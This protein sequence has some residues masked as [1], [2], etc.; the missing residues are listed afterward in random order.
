V[1]RPRFAVVIVIFVSLSLV[2]QLA[3][4]YVLRGQGQIAQAYHHAPVDWALF[5]CLVILGVFL[6]ILAFVF[7]PRKRLSPQT[8]IPNGVTDEQWKE[9]QEIQRLTDSL[10]D[11]AK[12][13]L[14]YRAERDQCEEEKR[15]LQK[16][17]D[18]IFTPLQIDA[19]QLSTELLVF[20][21][22]L[23][24]PP[25][26]KYTEQ[27]I[28]AMP[29]AKMK[30]L[31]NSNDPDFSDACE[32]FYGQKDPNGPPLTAAGFARGLAAT[33]KMMNPWYEKVKAS[34]ALEFR[35]KVERLRN[36]FAVEG[37]PEDALLTQVEG[38]Q[39]ADRIRYVSSKLWELGY[40]IAERDRK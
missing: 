2:E 3:M 15:A 11:S 12:S 22:R 16:R 26:P 1:Y 37:L 28:R 8:P 23:G 20:L 19:I 24:P 25:A 30:E 32:I 29:S 17:F 6:V 14:E 18:D 5:S 39:C 33:A 36:R 40:R 34:Y 31:I 7:G 27:E 13:N 4:G 35:D 21:K 9:K 10:Y 38:S